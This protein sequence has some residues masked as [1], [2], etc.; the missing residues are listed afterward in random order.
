VK[1]DY[2]GKASFIQF[3]T[4]YPDFDAIVASQI[5]F[6]QKPT[7]ETTIDYP[8]EARVGLAWHGQKWGAEADV[9]KM[10]WSS[11]DKLP[12]TLAAYPALSSVRDEKYEDSNTYRLGIEYKHSPEISWQLGGLW[13]PTPVPVESVTP[14]LPDADRWGVSIGA[15]FALSGKTDLQIGYLFLK[16]KDR[17]TGGVN[18]DGY[19]GMYK[20][21][22][23]LLGFTL[24]H[25]F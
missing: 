15:T 5:P 22:A 17:S 14:L 23:N 20:T 25:R 18:P 6:G 1:I 21:T 4:G 12:I 3:E 24:V 16:F 7:G 2:K 10:G 13:D 19:E 8:S 11:F 9:V